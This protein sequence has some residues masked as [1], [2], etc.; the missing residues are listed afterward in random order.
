[1]REALQVPAFVPGSEMP[2]HDELKRFPPGFP[3]DHPLAPHVPLEGR[4][5]GYGSDDEVCS[6]TCPIEWRGLRNAVPVFRFLS[7][8]A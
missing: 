1:M 5:F 3:Q 2:R 4:V 7:T 6:P 8:F